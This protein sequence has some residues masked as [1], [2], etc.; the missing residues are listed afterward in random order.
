MM[1]PLLAHQQQH[2]QHRHQPSI[3]AA[4]FN[5]YSTLSAT[6]KHHTQRSNVSTDLRVIHRQ[7]SLL[8]SPPSAGGRDDDSKLRT[9]NT[10]ER[11]DDPSAAIAL[12]LSS[13]PP[14]KSPSSATSPHSRSH[15]HSPP[16]P[17]APP[18]EPV[19]EC[20]SAALYRAHLLPAFVRQQH[21]LLY[22]QIRLCYGELTACR[23]QLGGSLSAQ[24]RI[25][26]QWDEVCLTLACRGTRV[27][28]YHSAVDASGRRW[29]R[30]RA[31]RWLQ[32]DGSGLSMQ[33]S[34][35]KAAGAV[36]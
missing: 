24:Q 20:E 33:W 27:C 30:E 9:P 8:L 2:Q 5:Y 17:S 25:E 19:P 32:L 10:K 1:S 12:L 23:A 3:L 22:A 15:T 6:P 14:P 18:L 34:R 11:L 26:Q 13:R 7:P 36:Q 28:K 4:P 29:G 21:D 31:E 35:R 16:Q